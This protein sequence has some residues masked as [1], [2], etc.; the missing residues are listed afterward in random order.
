MF[1]VMNNSLI[2]IYYNYCLISSVLFITCDVMLIDK[3]IMYSTKNNVN[4]NKQ[5]YI[6]WVSY[7]TYI[8]AFFVV[9]GVPKELYGEC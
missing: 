3:V 4:N 5:N 7:V 1:P 9:V 2:F 6:A 8:I